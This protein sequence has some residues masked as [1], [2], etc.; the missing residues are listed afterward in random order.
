[1]SHDKRNAA[2]RIQF[3]RLRQS[4]QVHQACPRPPSAHLEVSAAVRCQPAIGLQN[5][6]H[7]RDCSTVHKAM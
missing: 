1:M 3:R 4:G 2:N 6:R 5:G 7:N